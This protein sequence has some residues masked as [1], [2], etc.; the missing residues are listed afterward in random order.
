MPATVRKL[1]LALCV[2]TVLVAIAVTQ[3]PFHYQVTRYAIH[4]RWVHRVDWRWFPNFRHGHLRLMDRDFVL[5]L[6]ML[7]PLGIGFA[8][9]RRAPRWR[10]VLE[11][12]LLGAVLA[13][14]LELAQL[15]T[16]WRTTSLADWW[17]NTASCFA[18]ALLVV[19]LRSS[20]R[21]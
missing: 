6:L 17:R 8:L 13:A 18:G 19:S 2:G 15:L 11:A 5:N 1:G 16:P 9:W 14:G 4:Y 20:A 21:P 7:V 10:V 3:Y 12:L